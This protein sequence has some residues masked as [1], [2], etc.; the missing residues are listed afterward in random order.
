MKRFF[1]E[2]PL[3]IIPK[4]PWKKFNVKQLNGSQEIEEHK[5][6]MIL[7]NGKNVPKQLPW[8]DVVSDRYENNFMHL[9]HQD[10]TLLSS[11]QSFQRKYVFLKNIV[12]YTNRKTENLPE[13][14]SRCWRYTESALVEE[15]GRFARCP[16][17]ER[18]F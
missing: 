1:S 17:Q 2:I 15:E 14:A 4:T 16:C 8:G 11:L 10:N 13:Q 5:K 7:K 18:K 12:E 3:R 9:D 6:V